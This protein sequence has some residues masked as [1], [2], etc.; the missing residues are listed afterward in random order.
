[1]IFIGNRHWVFPFLKE[2]FSSGSIHVGS[3]EG[4]K[5]E[6]LVIKPNVLSSIPKYHSVEEKSQLPGV[7]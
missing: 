6:M 4:Q 7:L 2:N 1:M 3:E 5:V